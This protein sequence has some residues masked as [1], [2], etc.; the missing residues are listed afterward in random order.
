VKYLEHKQNIS[1]VNSQYWSTYYLL[2]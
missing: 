2:C 1:F